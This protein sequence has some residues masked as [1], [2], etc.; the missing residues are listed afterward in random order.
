MDEAEELI[1]VECT[2]VFIYN[3]YNLCDIQSGYVEID[4]LDDSEVYVYLDE[5]EEVLLLDRKLVH[6]CNSDL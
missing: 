1:E 2:H 3:P 6:A 5:E 4:A